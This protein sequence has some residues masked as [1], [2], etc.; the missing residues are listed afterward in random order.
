MA[1][2][3]LL[4][5]GLLVLIMAGCAAM[6]ASFFRRVAPDEALVLNRPGRGPEATF[7]S[8]MVFPVL[9]QAH[10]VSLREQAV[11]VDRHGDRALRS[12]DDRAVELVATFRLRVNNTQEDVLKAFTAMGEDA[13]TLEAVR[14]RFEPGFSEALET[15]ARQ[16]DAETIEKDRAQFKDLVFRVI[17]TD[18]DG[19]RLED[20][21]VTAVRIQPGSAYR[22]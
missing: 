5:V 21:S 7:A 12:R 14:S 22:G 8:T 10:R 1:L 2:T 4:G 19:F 13:S 17:G 15:V 11:G 6:V 20:V 9:H 3:I 18:L 16:L